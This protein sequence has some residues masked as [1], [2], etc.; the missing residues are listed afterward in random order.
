MATPNGREKLK[1]AFWV[2]VPFHPPGQEQ[3]VLLGLW[4]IQNSQ[5]LVS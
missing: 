5:P 2:G 4:S 3:L 1:R